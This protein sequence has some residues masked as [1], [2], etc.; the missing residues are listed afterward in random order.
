MR[1]KAVPFK[2][3]PDFRSVDRVRQAIDLELSDWFG[4]GVDDAAIADFCQVVSELVNNAV[5][6]GGCTV[7]EAKL[8]LESRMARFV[9]VTDGI[10]FD[11]AAST[12]PMPEVDAA[13]ELPEGGFGL[14]I[15]R[16]LSDGVHYHFRDGRN[17]T[18][19][20]KVFREV[21]DGTQD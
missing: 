6:H 19:V 12:A 1:N 4:E 20:S 3:E 15:I 7:I 16:D 10:C 21:G 2:L 17:V 13:G 18:E 5:E 14:A 9:L 11:T 8:L